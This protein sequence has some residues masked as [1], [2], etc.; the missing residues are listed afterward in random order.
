MLR[1]RIFPTS[2]PA[3]ERI[4]SERMRIVLCSFRRWVPLL[5]VAVL[6]PLDLIA[7]ETLVFEQPQLAGISGFRAFWDLPVVLADDGLVVET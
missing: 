6:T 2:R 1:V 7:A 4:D 3:A 5:A